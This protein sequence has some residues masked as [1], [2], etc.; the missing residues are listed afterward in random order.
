MNET[1]TRITEVRT[2]GVP[3]TNQDRAL[4]LYVGAL[5]FE[6]RVDVPSGEGER[7][8]EVA[9]AEATTTIALVLAREGVATGIDTGIRFTTEDA[10]A[11]H[12]DLRA[13]GVDVDPDVLRWP[14]VPA[15]F[16][17]RDADGNV[18][19]VVERG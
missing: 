17:F 1:R 9:P 2:V 11:D 4:E 14:G 7:W 15:M 12:A 13:R 18:L 10:E 5:G 8:I 3:V 19:F 6:K 16:S